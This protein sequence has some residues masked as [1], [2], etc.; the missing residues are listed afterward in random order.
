MSTIGVGSYNWSHPE[1]RARLEELFFRG[2]GF[3]RV[4]SEECREFWSFLERYQ[5]FQEREEGG[6]EGKEKGLVLDVPMEYDA[7]YRINLSVV[8]GDVE[9]AACGV[10]GERRRKR[11]RGGDRAEPGEG[12]IPRGER[13]AFRQALRHYAEFRQKQAF[14]R[15]AQLLRS[16]RALPVAGYRARLLELV[17]GSPVVVV[18]GDTGCGKSTQVPQYLLEDW[19]QAGERLACTQPRRIAC[20]SLARRVG[21]ESLD[22]SAVGYRVRFEAQAPPGARLLFLTEGLLLRQLQAAGPA[23]ERYRAVIV[24]EAHERH[25]HSDFLLGVLR[26]LQAARPGFRLLLMSATIN[27]QLF[28]RYFDGAPIL[29]VPGRLFPIKVIYQP[30]EEADG[31]SGERFQAGPY[32]RV[33]QAIDQRYPAEERGDLLVFLSGA[34]EIGAVADA[35]RTYAN[36]TKRWIVLPLH[37]GLSATEQ[38]KVFDIAPPGVRKCIVA[39]N[40]A[41]TSVTIDGVRFVVDSGKVKEMSYDPKAKMH[42]L[43]E[44][45]ISQ[46]SAEQR[47]GR[48]G[49]TGP[50]VCYRLYAESD[51]DAFA[52]YPVP[53][54][55]RVALDALVLQ[56]KSMGLGDPR[57]FPFIEPPPLASVETA[58]QYLRDQGAL[59]SGENLTA[60]GRLLAQLPV[61]VVIGKMLILGCAFEIVEP[62]LT[63]AAALS[64]QSP[65]VRSRQTDPDCATARRPLE[66]DDGDPFTLLNAFE[67]WLQV[68]SERRTDS[69]KWCRRRGLVEQ[70]LYEMVNLRQQFKTLLRD[71]GLLRV[72]S[73]TDE[74]SY[75]RQRRH[76]ERRELQRA[77]R[78]HEE[79]DGRRRK[80][81]RLEEEGAGS[82]EDEGPSGLSRG[83]RALDIQDVKFK[84][85]HNV[86]DLEAAA[87]SSWDLGTRRFQ[88]LKLLMCRGLYPQ[89][90]VPDEFNTCRKDSEQV[91]HTKDKQGVVLHPT[92]VF[93]SNPSLLYP[94][95]GKEK[96][97]AQGPDDPQSSQQQLLAFVSL[98]ETSKPYLLNCVRVPALQTLLL[99][100]RSLDTSA[101]CR[102]LAVDGWL[103]VSLGDPEAGAGILSTV[104]R[105]RDSWEQAL[106]AQLQAAERRGLPRGQ[107]DDEQEEE[108]EQ[109]K[110]R[111]A[112]D[113]LCR[114]LLEFLEAKVPYTLRRLTGLEKQHLYVGPQTVMAMSSLP[115]LDAGLGHCQPDPVKGGV[116]VTDYLTYN[117]LMDNQDFYSECLRTFWSCPTCD[118]YMP[119][120]PLERMQHEASCAK[121][122]RQE[123]AAAIASPDLDAAPQV[124]SAL[125]LP[126]RCEACEQD[127]L[128]TPTQIL[129]HKM[130]HRRT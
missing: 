58:V 8:T 94:K 126:Y 41:E 28:S 34:A 48:A 39:T 27:V 10:G 25:L 80:L 102:R 33:M 57:T 125:R 40:I 36:L 67:E 77:K 55:Q 113:T 112:T 84:L 114:Q 38:D 111:R 42:R 45:W 13:A 73:T 14:G 21:L 103:E 118:L 82:S 81:L 120:T 9:P 122:G 104:T 53:E 128:F 95:E 52:P 72:E 64:L 11:R 62:V 78:L 86:K 98:L 116:A 105:L 124:A 32:L 44:F 22:P 23:L 65:F 70:R 16:R 110:R 68:K 130:Q 75:H 83:D 54:I 101:D 3:I 106:S 51:Y 123:L 88:L 31:E 60:V 63:L 93:A 6:K 108:E 129:K 127:F 115:G 89:L 1:T 117:C 91:F 109:R 47:K 87:S 18:A 30:I 49:R 121:E 15:L 43:Q 5:R 74:G 69:R 46:A 12:E 26:G 99:L 50:G 29:Q 79:Q 92:S 37:S 59:D 17:R 76:R 90:A 24:D 61:D 119:F 19:A 7:S 85:K 4:G 66:S 71:H 56:M 35:A 96:E 97:Q 100:G 2:T 20:L 107:E